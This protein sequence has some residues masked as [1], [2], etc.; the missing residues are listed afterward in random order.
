MIYS[1]I[2]ECMSTPCQN[3]ATCIDHVNS[4]SCDCTGLGFEG[5]HCEGKVILYNSFTLASIIRAHNE[6]IINWPFVTLF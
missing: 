4:Y 1:D 5:T 6:L 3:N 2:D